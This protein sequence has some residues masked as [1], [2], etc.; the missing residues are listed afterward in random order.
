MEFMILFIL[1]L[2][3]VGIALAVSVNRS[4]VIS[5][6]QIDL[7]SQRVLMDVSDR[8]NTVYLEGDGFSINVTLPDSIL[9]MDYTVEISSNQAVLRID[10]T[11]FVRNLLTDNISGAVS[12]GT[13]TF[14]NQ[15]GQIIITG[16]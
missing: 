11:T 5:R 6:A 1:F 8:I 10:G 3:A 16:V 7:E 15:D 13:S 4:N 12:K 9:M 14:L 2:V